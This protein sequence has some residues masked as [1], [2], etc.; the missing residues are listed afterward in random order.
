[1]T[2]SPNEKRA[3]AESVLTLAFGIALVA[4]GH[5]P[6]HNEAEILQSAKRLA[7]TFADAL[8]PELF[9]ALA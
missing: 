8:P 7:A 9:E 6:T 1:M 4:G 5:A 2:T 3:A